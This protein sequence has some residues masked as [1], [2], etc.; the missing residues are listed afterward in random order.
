MKYLLPILACVLL[1]GGC[2]TGRL[3]LNDAIKSPLM[4]TTRTPSA[5]DATSGRSSPKETTAH[6]AAAEPIEASFSETAYLDRF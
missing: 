4:K 6:A 5:P 3:S 1:L 2:S